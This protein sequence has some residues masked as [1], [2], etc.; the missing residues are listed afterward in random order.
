[1]THNIIAQ[2]Q[3]SLRG[4]NALLNI[5]EMWVGMAGIITGIVFFYDPASINRNALAV[6]IGHTLS[7]IWN[8]SYFLSGLMVWYGLLRP[9]PR[10]EISG[11]FLLG[12][13]AGT[14]GIAIES[15]FGLRGTATAMTLISLCAASWV[16]ASFVYTATQ[17]L[18]G[19]QTHRDR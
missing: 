12:A 18:A 4:R 3:R 11:L 19:I 6:V 7:V 1:M 5:F 9:S 13:S 14:N 2:L 15:I 17:N 10:V 16:R 8:L